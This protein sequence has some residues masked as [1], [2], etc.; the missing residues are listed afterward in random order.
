MKDSNT[1][2]DTSRDMVGAGMIPKDLGLMLDLDPD[3]LNYKDLASDP[4]T[5]AS[6]EE[7]TSDLGEIARERRDS[8]VGSSLTRVSR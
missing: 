5:P 3:L 8:G 4:G 1:H 6:R 2:K 7:D